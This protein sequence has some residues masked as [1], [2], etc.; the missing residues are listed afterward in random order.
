MQALVDLLTEL[1]ASTYSSYDI[2]F[3]SVSWRNCS[4]KL[5][6]NVM[7]MNRCFIYLFINFARWL[8]MPQTE[9]DNHLQCPVPAFFGLQLDENVIFLTFFLRSCKFFFFFPTCWLSP[10]FNTLFFCNRRNCLSEWRQQ[11]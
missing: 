11:L 5:F 9:A 2:A 10:V 8:I 7:L 3:A 1:L 6:P 4:I